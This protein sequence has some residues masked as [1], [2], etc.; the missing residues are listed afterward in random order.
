MRLTAASRVRRLAVEV[1]G[2]T[3]EQKL[4]LK[5]LSRV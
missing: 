5:P 3:G 4:D 1:A 2:V